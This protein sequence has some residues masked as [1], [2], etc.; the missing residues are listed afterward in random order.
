M[1]IVDLV[2]LYLKKENYTSLLIFCIDFFCQ[3]KVEII[4]SYNLSRSSNLVYTNFILN[5]F[6]SNIKT[7]LKVIFL[8]LKYHL[9]HKIYIYCFKWIS[10]KKHYKKEKSKTQQEF[11]LFSIIDLFQIAL[12]VPLFSCLNW[13]DVQTRSF[14]P[15]IFQTLF[16]CAL[17]CIKL[18]SS[19]CELHVKYTNLGCYTRKLPMESRHW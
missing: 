17:I 18:C 14:L 4:I 2:L 9:Y 15:Q 10:G 19:W 6:W 5:I 11:L 12:Q 7:N 13:W 3:L 8:S 1:W 16:Y